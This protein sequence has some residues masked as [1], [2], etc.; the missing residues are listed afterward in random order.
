MSTA[1]TPQER[2]EPALSHSG[3]KDMLISPLRFWYRHIRPDRE[4]VEPTPEM[5]FG[6]ALHCAVLEPHQF[7]QRYAR[8]VDKADFPLVTIEDLRGWLASHGV[9][10]KGTRKGPI[11]D[12]VIA[13][14]S[15]APVYDVA[16]ADHYTKHGGKVTLP[17]ETWQRVSDAAEALQAEPKLIDILKTGRAEVALTGRDPDT[18][19]MLR[20]VLDWVCPKITMDIKTFTYRK[21]SID[22]SIADAILYQGY[23]RQAY[24]YTALRALNGE[25]GC[26]FVIPFVE[27]EQP[28]EVRLKIL[29]G[30]RGGQ[31][32][33][34]WLRAQL[35]V[36]D[37]LRKFRECLDHFGIEKPWRYAQEIDPLNDEEI[38]G[39]S[40]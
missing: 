33:L 22:R 16:V 23:H 12:Q 24:T 29:R 37:C 19:V 34:Y 11:V 7:D 26:G 31:P 13:V 2:A 35:E 8:A 9:E 30:K 5:I 36:R 3:M 14:D 1:L 15:R 10:A 38:P 28:H 25:S 32:N 4:E 18:K 39:L 40:L 21:G 27:S 6:S 20:G 17:I